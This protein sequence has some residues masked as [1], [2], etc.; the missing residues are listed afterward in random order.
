MIPKAPWPRGSL[1]HFAFKLFHNIF[2]YEP[3][4]HPSSPG[5]KH[6]DCHLSATNGWG[7]NKGRACPMESARRQS[8][9]SLNKITM[10]HTIFSGASTKVEVA[11]RFR[12]KVSFYYGVLKMLM[13]Q[14]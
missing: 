7:L 8:V 12:L 11:F 4:L 5:H 3:P 13:P 1:V 10:G 2:P 9:A 14:P 6:W